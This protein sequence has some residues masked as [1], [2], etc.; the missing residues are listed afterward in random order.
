MKK[1]STMI[2]KNYSEL[3]KLSTFE[4]RFRYLMLSGVIGDMTFNGHRYL[5]QRLYRCPEWESIRREVI[6]RDKGCD[7][8]LDGYQINGRI[9]VH[10][11]NPITIADVIERRACVFD[12]ENLI[13]TSHQTHN[14]IHYGDEDLLPR[15]PVIREKNDTIPWR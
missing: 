15:R 3:M 7:L 9:L 12:L 5:N 8:A 14:A 2:I 4:D 10:H 1:T 13:S 6:I 11:I